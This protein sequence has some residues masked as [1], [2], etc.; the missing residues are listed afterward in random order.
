M[1]FMYTF[2]SSIVM[3]IRTAFFYQ[4][5]S[6]THTQVLRTDTNTTKNHVEKLKREHELKSKQAPNSQIIPFSG[7]RTREQN[8]KNEA[9]SRLEI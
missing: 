8:R 5:Y 2:A 3:E 1:L 4:H 9:L 7:Y 6:K